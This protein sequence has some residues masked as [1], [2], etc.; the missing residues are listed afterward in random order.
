MPLGVHA[1]VESV[2]HFEVA[3]TPSGLHAG[4]C[5]ELAAVADTMCALEVGA[6]GAGGTVGAGGVAG[7]ASGI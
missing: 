1:L 3:V 6:F 5:G 4:V 7:G 2:C